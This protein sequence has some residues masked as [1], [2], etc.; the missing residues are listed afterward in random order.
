MLKFVNAEGG[1]F[2]ILH[3]TKDL[4]EVNISWL[5]LYFCFVK[6]IVKIYRNNIYGV[7]GTLVFHILLFSVFLLAEV[8]MK[9]SVREEVLL[10][11]FPEVLPEEEETGK[12]EEKKEDAEPMASP[13]DRKSVV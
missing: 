10:I 3:S 8:D 5:I 11:E 7:M 2:H 9:G 4:F 1:V 6:A 12:E 13:R